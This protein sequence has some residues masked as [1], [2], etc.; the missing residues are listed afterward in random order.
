M[1]NDSNTNKYIPYDQDI[2][3]VALYKVGNAL[4]K[5]WRFDIA[6]T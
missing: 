4:K 2:D 5:W 6:L 3:I 1:V